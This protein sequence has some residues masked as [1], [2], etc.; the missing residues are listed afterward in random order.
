ML[1]NEISSLQH[2]IVK[3]SVKLRSE[4]KVR[5]EN[6]EVLIAGIKQVQEA[7]EIKTLFVKKGFEAKIKAKEMFLVT[8]E[9]LKKITGVETPEELAAIVP[10][11]KSASLHGK[12]WILAL[13]GVSDPGNLGTL[14]RSALA[15][16]WEGAFLTS[17]CVDPYNDKALRSAKGATFR[18]PLR[19]GSDEELIAYIQKEGLRP[20]VADM[21]GT[22][23]PAIEK[24]VK[25]VLILGSESQGSSL[26]EQFD[27][28]SIPIQGIESLN[29]AAAGAILL[30]NLRL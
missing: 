20:L 5:Y 22:P 13:D 25:T 12:R 18:I 16:G 19:M 15:L 10:M 1:A 6:K 29:V 21:E 24:G 3:Y 2:P 28:V 17:K 4:R 23:L 7:S 27:R 9:I 8:E 30:Y 11:P 26:K 14:L